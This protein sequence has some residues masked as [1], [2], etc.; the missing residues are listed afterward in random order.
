MWPCN[1]VV[2]WLDLI[3]QETRF[4][5]LRGYHRRIAVGYGTGYAAT[6]KS[7]RLRRAYK[8]AMRQAIEPEKVGPSRPSP[9]I[10]ADPALD[11]WIT[12]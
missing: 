6:V 10:R 4:N 12:K 7:I 11:N 2:Q 5:S 8:E 9:P 3:N 1:I